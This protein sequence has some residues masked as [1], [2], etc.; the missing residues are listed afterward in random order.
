M[1][2]QQVLMLVLRFIHIFSGVFWAGSAFFLVSF[3]Q[4]VV[5]E[6]GP[7]G[8][9]VMQ[10]LAASRFS[11]ALPAVSVLTVLSGLVLYWL[12]S[13]GLQLEIIMTGPGLGFAFGGIA[14]LLALVIGLVVSMPVTR[15]MAA[16]SRELIASGNPPSP[17][18]MTKIQALQIRMATG[19]M[20]NTILLAL[21]VAAMAIARYL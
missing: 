1:A 5:R 13:G 15:S 6:S 17:E 12:D 7:E 14:G 16:I 4:P 19:A 2:P 18:Q 3:L 9:K 20:W 11:T 21:A 8:G 10:R